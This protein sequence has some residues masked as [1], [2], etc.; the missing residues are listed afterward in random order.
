MT[1]VRFLVLAT[2]STLVPLAAVAQSSEAGA[3]PDA[4]AP[5]AAVW[6]EKKIDFTYVGYTAHFSCDGLERKVSQI[7]A[8]IGARPGYKVTARSCFNPRH[9]VEWTPMLNIVAAMPQ[10]ATPELLAELA[11]DTSKSELA[12]KAGGKPPPV[13]EAT[14][15]FPART[16]RIDFRDSQTGLLQPGDCELV[17]EMR[18]AVFVPLGAKIVVNRM[19]CVPHQ[20]N[21][22][23]IVLSIDVLEPVP[24]T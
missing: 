8:E 9:G 22:G 21:N 2:C 12:A 11:K 10:P 14:A 18:D 19:A 3:S 6:V 5:V 15:E 7:L 13:A 4:P 23:I 16:R 1:I 20:L 24:S 17:D